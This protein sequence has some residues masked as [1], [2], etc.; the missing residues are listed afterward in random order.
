MPVSIIISHFAPQVNCDKYFNLLKTNIQL[1]RNQ[2]FDKK[3]EI[4]LCDDGSYWSG[5]LF[6]KTNEDRIVE[7]DRKEIITND[8]FKSLDVDKYYGLPDINKYRG[9]ILKEKAIINA[10]YEKI[11][12]LDDDHHLSSLS[13]LRRVSVYLDHYLYL[14]GRII[15]PDRIPQTFFSRNANGT[16]YG[17]RKSLYHDCGGFSRFL[18][19]NGYGEDNDIQ[20]RFFKYLSENS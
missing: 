18:L 19:L 3:L 1:I 14:K 9:I 10:R 17:F 2:K 8:L 16:T 6:E 15:G 7:M 13:S 11:F 12:I 4:I 5:I 20:F